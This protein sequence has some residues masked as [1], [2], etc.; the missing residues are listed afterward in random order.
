VLPGF[1]GVAVHDGWALYRSYPG[2]EHGLFYADVRVYADVGLGSP[3]GGG[4]RRLG[5]VNAVWGSA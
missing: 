3:F 4:D 5:A 1:E 2:C